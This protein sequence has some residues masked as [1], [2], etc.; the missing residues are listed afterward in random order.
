MRFDTRPHYQLFKITTD[1]IPS[2]KLQLS[3]SKTKDMQFV[4]RKNEEVP[5]N[6]RLS[7]I[8][9]SYS[10]QVLDLGTCSCT[11]PTH[12]LIILHAFNSHIAFQTETAAYQQS[13]QMI[14]GVY[15]VSSVFY[16]LRQPVDKMSKMDLLFTELCGR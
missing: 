4:N 12:S 6:R 16:N 7:Q 5:R 10:L 8:S 14:S 1:P 11:P 3:I 15:K 2:A 13:T 9:F